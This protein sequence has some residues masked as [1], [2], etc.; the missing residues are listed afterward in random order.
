MEK[1]SQGESDEGRERKLEGK[2]NWDEGF[3]Q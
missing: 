3:G 1:R 2:R